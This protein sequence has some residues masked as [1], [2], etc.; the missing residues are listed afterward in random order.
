MVSKATFEKAMTAALDGPEV[1]KIKF[2][3]HEFNVKKATVTA[4]RVD[5]VHVSGRISHH[6]S[7][8]DDDQV[9]YTCRITAGQT[10]TIDQVDFSI[11][12]SIGM[13]VLGAA[14]DLLEEWLKERGEGDGQGMSTKAL[15]TRSEE[16]E[17]R[18]YEDSKK[19]LD[20]SWEGEAKMLMVNIVG[21]HAIR[22]AQVAYRRT[23]PGGGAKVPPKTGPR[24]TPGPER[25]TRDHRT[26]G[27]HT[28]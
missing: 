14:W 3:K 5:G 20:G 1:K 15:A 7:F 28:P 4:S 25:T 24:T 10:V 6:R 12:R 22:Q 9:D 8:M 17:T 18:I 19:L 21:R 11:S 16:A 27:T 2:E 26:K 23:K 13:K